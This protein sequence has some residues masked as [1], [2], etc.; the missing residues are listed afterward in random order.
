MASEAVARALVEG[1]GE[2]V[3]DPQ[4]AARVAEATQRLW[5]PEELERRLWAEPER[6]PALYR[7]WATGLGDGG[8]E[9]A[10][11]ERL[12][13]YTVSIAARRATRILAGGTGMTELDIDLLLAMLQI[14]PHRFFS[15][16][17]YRRRVVVSWEPMRHAIPAA[18]S[19]FRLLEQLGARGLDD[20]DAL[21]TVAAGWHLIER[22]ST[23]R[24]LGTRPASKTSRSLVEDELRPIEATI[25]SLPSFLGVTASTELLASLHATS[26]RRHLMVLAGRTQSSRLRSALS[27]R[28][29]GAAILEKVAFLPTLG[30]DYS[31][32][33]RDP[34]SLIRREDGGLHVVLRGHVQRGRES[35]EWMGRA[36]VQGLPT[37]L[38][39]RWK[40][41]TWHRSELPF[42]NG[43][44]LDA[45]GVSWVSL[46]SLEP[47]ILE[48]LDLD[49]LP[50]DEFGGEVGRDYLEAAA[51]AAAELA[52]LRGRPVRF[53]HGL[54]ES[55]LPSPTRAAQ[56]HDLGG[57]A[58]IDL[59]S[60]LTLLPQGNGRVEALV[61]DVDLGS[62]LV[63]TAQPEDLAGLSIY[64]VPQARARA[65]VLTGHRSRPARRLDLYLERVAEH[66]Q[67]IGWKVRRLPVLWIDPASTDRADRADLAPFLVTWN[68]VVVERP[69]SGLVAEGFASGLAPGDEL[70]R[71]VFEDAGWQLRLHPPLVESIVRNGGY[72]CSTQHVRRG[73]RLVTDPSSGFLDTPGGAF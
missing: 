2:L 20:F 16:A 56:L 62:S 11:D 43:Q 59:D 32:W 48:L 15:D 1:R 69:T 3:N 68:N 35:D 71:R 26:P 23:D 4:L 44:I 18:G 53:V 9:E 70:A 24:Q 46:H 57:G 49:R 58:G 5:A 38:D 8:L 39:E 17:A 14:D 47:R 33:P 31:P 27:S 34:L 72:R 30:V 40:K 37:D 12:L 6:I 29:R 41:P 36:L 25:L 28:P 60:M 64:G 50:V 63:E 7:T 55:E 45:G 65:T 21:E 54:P 73:P 66:L 10:R 42:H 13:D 51:T 22:R 19:R 67:R 61:A 52:R